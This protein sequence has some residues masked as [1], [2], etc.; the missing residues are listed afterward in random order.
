[1]SLV[2]GLLQGLEFSQDS[3]RLIGPCGFA[4]RGKVKDHSLLSSDTVL[5]PG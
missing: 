2:I 5:Y 4:H 1:M 3:A